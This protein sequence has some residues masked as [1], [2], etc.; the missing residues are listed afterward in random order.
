MG[1][2][3]YLNATRF[4]S[5]DC[6]SGEADAM[7]YR[8]VL[9]ASGAANFISKE[10]S[11]IE[12]VITVAYWR[13]ANA[14]HKWLVD[15]VQDG[16]DDCGK[17]DVSRE[18]LQQLLEC[19]QRIL[20]TSKEPDPLAVAAVAAE[21]LPTQSGFFFGSTEYDEGYLDDIRSTV[22]QLTTALE[23]PDCWDFSYHASW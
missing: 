13:K 6:P 15:N 20:E 12:V 1:L 2:D 14:I 16:V 9:K 22:T 18:Q 4:I 8:Q 3:M 23:M 19:C 21:S 10:A 11:Y 17:Y 5:G 7:A